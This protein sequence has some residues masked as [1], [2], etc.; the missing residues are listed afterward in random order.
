MRQDN[1]D[2]PRTFKARANE[3]VGKCF[4]KVSEGE[5]AVNKVLT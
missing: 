5:S 1:Q 2:H 4:P 3:Q